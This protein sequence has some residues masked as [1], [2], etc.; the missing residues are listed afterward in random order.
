MSAPFFPFHLMAN[1]NFILVIILSVKLKQV[2]FYSFK[3][4]LFI[5]M[6]TTCSSL[7]NYRG[8]KP[9]TVRGQNFFERVSTGLYPGFITQKFLPLITEPEL[10]EF[11]PHLNYLRRGTSIYLVHLELYSVFLDLNRRSIGTGFGGSATRFK[12]F[13]FGLRTILHFL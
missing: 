7:F 2:M 1:S 3:F 4:E 8:L 11:E 9:D 10:K 13:K 12:F 5:Q 6:F